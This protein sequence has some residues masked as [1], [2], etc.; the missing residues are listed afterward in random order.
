[1]Q[2]VDAVRAAQATAQ[3]IT[4]ASS[5]KSSGL[6]HPHVKRQAA[7]DGRPE[8]VPRSL[9]AAFGD[10]D[11]SMIIASLPSGQSNSSAFPHLVGVGLQSV[12]HQAGDMIHSTQDLGF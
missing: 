2:I 12:A 7:G 6:L 1:M 3:A 4:V 5:D 11:H 9:T 8:V 10:Q